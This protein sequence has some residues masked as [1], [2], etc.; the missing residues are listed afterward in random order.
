[1]DIGDININVD[2]NIPQVVQ[3]NTVS[4]VTN[5]LQQANIDAANNIS[6]SSKQTSAHI[7]PKNILL[8]TTNAMQGVNNNTANNISRSAKQPDVQQSPK[9]ILLQTTNAMQGVNN[10]TANNIYRSAKQSGLPDTQKDYFSI[11]NN[12]LQNVNNNTAN[13]I[14]RSAKQSVLPDIQKDY[15]SIINNSL[16]N[17]NNNAANNIYRSAKQSVLPDT[18]KDYFSIVNNSLQ[19]VNS[20]AIINIMKKINVS[21]ALSVN[22]SLINRTNQAMQDSVDAMVADIRAKF[23]TPRTYTVKFKRLE[24]PNVHNKKNDTTKSNVNNVY[25]SS[26]FSTNDPVGHSI[27]QADNMLGRLA[28]HATGYKINNNF[29]KVHNY[30]RKNSNKTDPYMKSIT[31]ANINKPNVND[32][33]NV[34]FRLQETRG[35]PVKQADDMLERIRANTN[36][37]A[38][39]NDK[40]ISEDDI[41]YEYKQQFGKTKDTTAATN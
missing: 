23:P 12:S 18:Q 30:T 24:Y 21:T 15:F 29:K 2:N 5:S 3:P 33:P 27:Q 36:N 7:S 10:N 8:Q 25:Y 6:R 13:N 11:I 4:G 35:N 41:K 20:S 40:I 37:V 32:L 1:M 39:S 19:N 16:Q 26:G 38:L 9:N 14:Y 17:V 31:Y 34:E 22:D 28:L